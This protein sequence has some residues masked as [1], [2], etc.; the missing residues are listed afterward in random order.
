MLIIPWSS[1]RRR[2]TYLAVLKIILYCFK[3]ISGLYI[4]FQKSSTDFISRRY[5]GISCLTYTKWLN[6][7]KL[8]TPFKYLRL[9]LIIDGSKPSE[10]NSSLL[11]QKI[12]NK[13]ASWKGK[14]LSFGGRLVLINLVVTALSL[15]Y[16]S[17]FKLRVWVVRKMEKLRRSFPWS[18]TT[19]TSGLSCEVS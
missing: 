5:D 7:P 9:S 11:L 1:S 12:E 3:L 14:Y 6:Y 17:F 8:N 10:S 2:K 15:Y 16:L 19:S 18:C 4:N 13:L